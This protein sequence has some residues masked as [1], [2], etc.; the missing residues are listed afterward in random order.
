MIF[1]FMPESH[2][3]INP[4]DVQEVR[5]LSGDVIKSICDAAGDL[6]LWDADVIS[7]EQIMDRY[8]IPPELR[9]T[10]HRYDRANGGEQELSEYLDFWRANIKDKR[11]IDGVWL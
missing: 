11:Y 6:Y 1:D 3:F 7:Y 9:S 4:E 2:I 10:A 5:T 8:C